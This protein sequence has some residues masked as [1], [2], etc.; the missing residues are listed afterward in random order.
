[1]RLDLFNQRA[2]FIRGQTLR[3]IPLIGRPL[4]DYRY[5]TGVVLSKLFIANSLATN[6][7]IKEALE[8]VDA[9]FAAQNATFM[10][11]F[12]TAVTL[13]ADQYKIPRRDFGRFR[14]AAWV[15]AVELYRFDIETSPLIMREVVH[16]SARGFV[17]TATLPKKL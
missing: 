16:L 17:K 10:Q 3:R 14:E 1:M 5:E 12:R 2:E 4:F 8:P 7:E 6:A 13:S 15:E 11:R 9:T